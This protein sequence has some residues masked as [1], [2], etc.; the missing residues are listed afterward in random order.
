MATAPSCLVTRRIYAC[1]LL[2]LGTTLSY[3]TRAVGSLGGPPK[4]GG[5]VEAISI[6]AV[7][8]VR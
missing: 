4:G 1:A 2:L 3:S 6:G 8:R 5:W 7:W